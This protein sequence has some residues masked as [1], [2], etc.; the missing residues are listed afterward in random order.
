[1]YETVII[2]DN[3]ESVSRALTGIF[4]VKGY[5]TVAYSSAEACLRAVDQ[6]FGP[7]CVIADLRLPGMGGIELQKNM[8]A[9]FPVI[10]LTGHADVSGAVTAIRAGAVEFIEKPAGTNTLLTAVEKAMTLARA[11]HADAICVKA[12]VSKMSLLTPR[13]REVMA[14]VVTGLRNKDVARALGTVEKTIKVHRAHIMQKLEL[15]SLA[16]MVRCADK[17]AQIVEL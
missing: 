1:M 5:Q 11:R 10:I 7:A 3:D 12:L 13:E 9:R 6:H 16:E 2:V 17:L 14:L 8:P 15:K 4:G